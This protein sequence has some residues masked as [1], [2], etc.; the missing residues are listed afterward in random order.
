MAFHYRD[1]AVAQRFSGVICS[2]QRALVYTDLSLIEL[3]K[4]V[5]PQSFGI[6]A[7]KT[8]QL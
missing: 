2:N 6:T 5:S 3:E 4:Q 7:E 1:T 8:F